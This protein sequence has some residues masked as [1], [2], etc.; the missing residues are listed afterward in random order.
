MT[1]PKS[2]PFS[3]LLG[4]MVG[5]MDATGRPQMR[6]DLLAAISALDAPRVSGLL[7]MLVDVGTVDA[8]EAQRCLAMAADVSGGMRLDNWCLLRDAIAEPALPKGLGGAQDSEQLAHVRAFIAR[9]IDDGDLPQAAKDKMRDSIDANRP[10]TWVMPPKSILSVRIKPA[11][12]GDG[13]QN[14]TLIFTMAPGGESFVY[15]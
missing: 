15:F 13:T 6:G 2:Q 7:R 10:G 3:A 9:Y 8:D 11:S 5:R 14:G 12:P 4:I 1:Q